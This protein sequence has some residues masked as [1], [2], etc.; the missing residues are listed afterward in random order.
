MLCLW[1]LISTLLQ[2]IIKAV[3]PRRTYGRTP[4]PPEHNDS[5]TPTNTIPKTPKPMMWL[6]RIPSTACAQ[7]G[8]PQ[9][10]G[11]GPQLSPG[12]RMLPLLLCMGFESTSGSGEKQ[13]VLPPR[14][15]EPGRA[16]ALPQGAGQPICSLTERVWR[17]NRGTHIGALEPVCLEPVCLEFPATPNSPAYRARQDCAQC[18]GESRGG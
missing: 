6:G 14:E 5:S 1:Q 16:G 13:L 12:A 10:E 15:R 7:G 17:S 9:I 3:A 11:V 4:R 2:R 8:Q 18:L